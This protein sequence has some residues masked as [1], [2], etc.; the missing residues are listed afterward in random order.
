MRYRRNL[1]LH[2]TI[3]DLLPHL[4][5]GK[6]YHLFECA[7]MAMRSLSNEFASS[8]KQRKTDE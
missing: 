2:S 7:R 6:E 1:V 8:F 4:D 3:K 5:L